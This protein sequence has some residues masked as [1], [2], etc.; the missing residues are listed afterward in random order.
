MFAYV[1]VSWFKPS[2]I[3]RVVETQQQDVKAK[4]ICDRI[5]RGVGPTDWVLHSDQGLRY[6]S[7]LFAPL[8]SREMSFF[9][10]FI[11]HNLQFILER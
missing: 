1:I 5:A 6:K 10:S 9:V 11:I 3:S 4:I 2:I 8:S 7:R